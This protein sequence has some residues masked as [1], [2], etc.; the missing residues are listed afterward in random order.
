ME[1]IAT[2]PKST[3]RRSL[4]MGAP[5]AAL[6]MATGGAGVAAPADPVP[7]LLAKWKATRDHYNT[8]P[9]T[10]EEAD[11][12]VFNEMIGYE[13]ELAATR[14]VSREGAVAQLQYLIEDEAFRD[15]CGLHL[16]VVENV[17]SALKSG[18]LAGV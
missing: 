14:P 10:T 8:M 6:A 16:Q 18:A 11:K 1:K 17:L 7:A 4:L 5:V 2:H 15:G 12:K 9:V 13:E 3:S